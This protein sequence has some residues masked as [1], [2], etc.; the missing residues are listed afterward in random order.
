MSFGWYLA[1]MILLII[2]SGIIGG[3]IGGQFL[4]HAGGMVTGV[5]AMLLVLIFGIMARY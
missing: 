4:G 5:G 3:A 1:L 2:V